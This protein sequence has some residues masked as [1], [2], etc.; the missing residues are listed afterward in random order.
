MLVIIQNAEPVSRSI[1]EV[2]WLDLGLAFFL[3]LIAV[4]ISLWQKLGLAQR[5]VVGAVRTVIQLVLV[6][7]LL[8]YIFALDRWYL[9]VA[10]LLLMMIVATRAAVNRH[11]RA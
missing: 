11:W 8:V 5:L 4:G 3:I 10:T 2:S 7:Y 6:G 1:I 9:V